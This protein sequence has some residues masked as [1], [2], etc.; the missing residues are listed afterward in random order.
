[1]KIK[2]SLV[3][4]LLT[5]SLQ[6]ATAQTDT[7]HYMFSFVGIN[8]GYGMNTISP[9][10]LTQTI[11]FFGSNG[12]VFTATGLIALKESYFAVP[13]VLGYSAPKFDVAAYGST[14]RDTSQAYNGYR[15]SSG[16]AGSY[17][18]IYAMT[19]LGLKIPGRTSRGAVELRVLVGPV[20]ASEPVISY[21]YTDPYNPAA[22]AHTINI[23]AATTVAFGFSPGISVGYKLTQ[24][25]AIMANAD[26]LFAQLKFGTYE[27]LHDSLNSEPQKTTIISSMAYLHLTGG[28]IYTLGKMTPN[29]V[30]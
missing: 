10:S 21:T 30:Y 8:A 6:F 15:Y 27:N 16:T 11:P 13:I 24:H 2:R 20:I 5:A 25:I 9:S 14:N 28:L 3:I 1:M 12:P 17:S 18:L 7:I 4:A 22:P 29:I 19:G 26:L 23:S